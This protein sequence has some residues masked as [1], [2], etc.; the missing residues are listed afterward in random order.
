MYIQAPCCNKWFECSEC[1][2]EIVK[3][4][5]FEFK[6]TYRFTCKLC[7]KVFSR[8]FKLFSE[9]DKL[10]SYCQNQ[11]VLPGITP[12]KKLYEDAEHIIDLSLVDII[13][14]RKAFFS[15]L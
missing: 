6:S 1:H 4:H 11:W 8:D 15:K 5:V 2:D 12:E 7:R 10:C 9:Q 3:T 14:Q 13:D